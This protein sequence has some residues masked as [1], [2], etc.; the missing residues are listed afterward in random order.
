MNLT[1]TEVCARVLI[2]EDEP[3]LMDALDDYLNIE[4]MHAVGVKSLREAQA[5]MVARGFDVLLLY[6]GLPDG[7]GLS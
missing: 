1:P 6:L 3:D 5:W 7:N 2:V 4:G